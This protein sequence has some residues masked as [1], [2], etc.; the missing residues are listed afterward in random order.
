MTSRT[1]ITLPKCPVCLQRYSV[2]VKPMIVQPCCHGIC[3]E[4]M[5]RCRELSEDETRCPKCREV[6]I[7][8]KPNYDMIDMLPEEYETRLWAQKLVDSMEHAGI[9]VPVTPKIE[10][11]SKLLVTRILNDDTIQT[12]GSKMKQEWSEND[13]HLVRELKQEFN[14]CINVLDMDFQ[15]ASRWIQ[16]M[17]LPPSFENYFMTQII[18]M[19]ENRRFLQPLDAVWLLDLIPMSV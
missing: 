9:S 5:E 2:D 4:C 1:Y 8:E 3:E 11:L 6:I 7:E 13:V 12:L 16:V 15:E 14:D 17:N 10:I 18:T 19:F